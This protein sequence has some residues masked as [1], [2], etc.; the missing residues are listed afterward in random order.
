MPCNHPLKAF[1]S[2][3]STDAGKEDFII[4]PSTAGDLLSVDWLNK[5]KRRFAT[6]PYMIQMNGKTFL[7]D[8]LA[9]PCGKCQ[10][11][12]SDRAKAW[13]VRCVLEKEY[14]KNCYFVTLTYA[15]CSIPSKDGVPCLDKEALQKF[16]KR[17]RKRG[18]V[19]RYFAC[20]EYG[21]DTKRPHYHLIL[22]TDDD[23]GLIPYGQN[24]FHSAL[25]DD[26]WKLGLHEV[27]IA[28]DGLIAYTAGYVEKKLYDPDWFSYPVKPFLTM[29]RKPGIGMRYLDDHDLSKSYKVYGLFGS[30]NS[31]PIPQAFKK[32]LENEVWFKAYKDL[33]IA[34]ARK[35]IDMVK[36]TYGQRYETE[37]LDAREWAMAQALVEKR[38]ESL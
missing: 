15:N 1:Y 25:I 7:K 22:F 17:V 32:K 13:K 16:F 4:C 35:S 18:A 29:S 5:K 3:L 33:C 2:G 31:S 36:V 37:A 11:C 9:I 12:R 30:S 10:G 26:C 21:S 19:V 14:F 38:K 28:D 23:I 34:Q 6:N 8:P 27:S 20:G 24:K